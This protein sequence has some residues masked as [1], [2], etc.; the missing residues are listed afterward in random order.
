MV[1]LD[2]PN[3]E[4]ERPNIETVFTVFVSS[5][6]VVLY[7]I[8]CQSNALSRIPADRRI[9]SK[10]MTQHMSWE[11]G[12]REARHMMHDASRCTAAVS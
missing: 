7:S 2:K 9:M 10:A 8:L 4:R 11:S 6:R 3:C 12:K 1:V 5:I